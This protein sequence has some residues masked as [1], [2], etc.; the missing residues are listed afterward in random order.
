[1]KYQ[2]K[3]KT[4]SR[5][6]LTNSYNVL[7]PVPYFDWAIVWDAGCEDMRKQEKGLYARK[8]M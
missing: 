6:D 3:G 7:D 8:G 4:G 1:M 2:P 5:A